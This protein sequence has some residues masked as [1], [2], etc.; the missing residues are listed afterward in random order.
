MVFESEIGDDDEVINYFSI[1]IITASVIIFVI[2]VVISFFNSPMFRANAYKELVTIE[3]GNFVEDIPSSKDTEIMDITT[4]RNMGSRVI[5]EIDDVSKYIISNEYNMII[6]QD[7]LY[8]IS[9]LNYA[10]VVKAWSNSGINGYVL[11]NCGTK[12]AKLVKLDD[13]MY[14]S[15]SATF[16]YNLK[17]HIRSK[18]SSAILGKEQFEIDDNGIPYYIV[19]TYK[20]TIGL[21]S[22]KVLDKVLIV[23]TLNG[24][25]SEYTM[26][27][28]PEWV[29][30]VDTVSHMMELAEYSYKYVHG[31]SNTLFSQKDV[32]TLSYRYLDSGFAGY[33]SIKTKN[34]ILYTT[35]VTSVNNDESI[36]GF[37]TL[38]PKTGKITFYDSKGAEESSA[39][40]S[41]EGAVQNYG[42]TAS[43]PQIVNEY[44]QETYFIALKDK[45]ETIVEYSYVNMRNY[46]IVA[47]GPTKEDALIQYGQKLN[48]G[49]VSDNNSEVVTITAKINGIYTAVENSTTYF[50]Y[51]LEGYNELF[52]SAITNN[53][54]QL[55]FKVNDMIKLEA[56]Y[57]NNYYSVKTIDNN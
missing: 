5:G 1:F 45:N 15:P 3:E 39:Q 21:F 48:E 35:C 24:E 42:Y 54:N 6:Y 40:R 13:K 32:K 11:V 10:S 36:V 38:S 18:Y 22:G 29:D 9:P 17:R 46:S 4:A 47:H 55:L 23:N 28:I 51:T 53:R 31:F 44:D 49:N 12:E 25:I 20:N 43:F 41:A 33:G 57:M 8:R 14:Y 16:S 37:I 34:G 30:H 27:N 52:V 56:V 19:P 7:T 2:M 50:Y 26:D